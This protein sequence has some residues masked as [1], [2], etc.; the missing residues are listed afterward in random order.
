VKDKKI[1]IN[2]YAQQDA[3]SLAGCWKSPPASQAAAREARDMR[4]RRDPKFEVPKTSNFGPRTLPRPTSLAS[5]AR[6]S[7]GGV[8]LLS[9]PC[10]PSTVCSAEMV[11]QQP[12]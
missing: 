12:A 3:S 2:T 10:R 6:L 5:L 8:L 11:F 1:E 7:C 9:K 4:E